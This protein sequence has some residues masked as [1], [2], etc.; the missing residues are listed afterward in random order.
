[1]TDAKPSLTMAQALDLLDQ[2]RALEEATYLELC[3]HDSRLGPRGLAGLRAYSTLDEV[4]ESMKV[5]EARIKAHRK[6][7]EKY[8]SRQD[9]GERIIQLAESLGLKIN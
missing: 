8:T 4:L 7:I 5:A 9:S 3:L 6:A 1:M 2:A